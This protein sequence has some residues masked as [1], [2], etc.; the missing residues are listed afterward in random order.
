[1]DGHSVRNEFAI[2]SIQWR[3][4]TVREGTRICSWLGRVQGRVETHLDLSQ[5]AFFRCQAQE[6]VGLHAERRVLVGKKVKRKEGRP[7]QIDA[8]FVNVVTELIQRLI[9]MKL[10]RILQRCGTL[11]EP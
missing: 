7:T 5:R 3:L 11:E 9:V 2:A 1:M 10:L 6:V 4:L 8:Q